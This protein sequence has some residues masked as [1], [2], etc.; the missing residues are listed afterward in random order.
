MNPVKEFQ[1]LAAGDHVW[2]GDSREPRRKIATVE[3]VTK[4][5]IRAD[6]DKFYKTDGR[7]VGPTWN[8][9]NIT[10]IA[11]PAEIKAYDAKLADEKR[12]RKAREKQDARIEEQRVAL[13]DM[14]LPNWNAVLRRDGERWELEMRELDDE[15]VIRMAKA[16]KAVKPR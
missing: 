8:S 13:T 6:H 4:T 2:L 16:L 5:L 9:W 10:G 12:E 7:K 11:T 1:D 15:T 14:F 3:R